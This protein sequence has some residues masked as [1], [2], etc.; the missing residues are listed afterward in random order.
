MPLESSGGVMAPART[1]SASARDSRAM[2]P[3]DFGV[4]VE[5][6]RDDERVLARDGHADVDAAVELELAVAVGAVGAREVAQRERARLDHEV[7]ER[8]G[9]L[10][11]GGGLE[12]LAQRDGLLHVDL[13][14]ED[15]VGRGRLR[16]GHPPRDG[17]LQAREVLLRGLAAAGLLVAGDDGSGDVLLR[18]LFLR[19]GAGASSSGSGAAPPPSAGASASAVAAPPLAAA[20]TSAF[21][22]RPPGPEPFELAE[23]DAHLARHPLGDR[24]GLD[25]V[26]AAVA[27]GR[28]GLR[29]R[30][31]GRLL[32][33]AVAGAVLLF[34][35]GLGLAPR[36]VGLLLLPPPAAP[37]PPRAPR[38]RRRSRSRHRAARSSRRPGACRPPWP[39]SSACRRSRPRRS[40]WPCP[41]RS[42]RALPRA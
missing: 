30:R 3:S 12:L 17:L 40:C 15:E 25:A 10:V 23:L 27:G 7:V 14:G 13:D 36:L 8:R 16:L 19:R 37:R 20:S 26:A 41:S 28:L 39:R 2:W 38:P 34:G 22:I 6:G 32:A 33:L 21:T 9:G 42:R 35:L 29:G 4:G 11:A 24:R 18:R 31:L 5:H 1:R